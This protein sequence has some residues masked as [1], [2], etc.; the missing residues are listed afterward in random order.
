M[1]QRPEVDLMGRMD[2]TCWPDV[3]GVGERGANEAPR[4]LAWVA[5]GSYP[6]LPTA[7]LK[8]HRKGLTGE[9]CSDPTQLAS[10]LGHGW[11]WEEATSLLDEKAKRWVS[12][13]HAW[14]SC[15]ALHIWLSPTC[16]ASSFM[17]NGR[18]G[19]SFSGFLS[20]ACCD[21][22]GCICRSW[23]TSGCPAPALRLVG[24]SLLEK[25]GNKFLLINKTFCLQSFLFLISSCGLRFVH[26]LWQVLL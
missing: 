20:Q 18:V 12:W 2:R 19:V 23:P 13:L 15:R 14:A 17:P 16:P 26:K 3:E 1:W 22:P 24:R 8:H 4:C 25:V 10:A 11:K 5:H 6:P 9:S 21:H 7:G